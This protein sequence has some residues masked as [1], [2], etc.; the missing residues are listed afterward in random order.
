MCCAHVCVVVITARTAGGTTVA[1][2][3]HAILWLP[4]HMEDLN[5]YVKH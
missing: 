1:M 4:G 5:V 2:W 3:A